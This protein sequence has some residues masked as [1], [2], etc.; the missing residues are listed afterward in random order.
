[1]ETTVSTPPSPDQVR[2]GPSDC[3]KFDKEQLPSVSATAKLS[4]QKPLLDIKHTEV[5]KRSALVDQIPLTK[6]LHE[7]ENSSPS[8]SRDMRLNTAFDDTTQ[9]EPSVLSPESDATVP[10]PTKAPLQST[11]QDLKASHVSKSYLTALYCVDL[12]SR[13]FRAS[14][15]A[16]SAGSPVTIQ[17]TCR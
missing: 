2:G 15:A 13:A 5:G 16:Y 9:Y 6:K 3:Q 12:V 17:L 4:G 1:M 10:Q 14:F 8:A 11:K 7:N